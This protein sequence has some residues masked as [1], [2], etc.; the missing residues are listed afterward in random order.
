M[1][2]PRSTTPQ[3]YSTSY[4]SCL[5]QYIWYSSMPRPTYT[6]SLISISPVAALWCSV[7]PWPLI[8]PSPWHLCIYGLSPSGTLDLFCYVC[9]MLASHYPLRSKVSV[10]S[11]FTCA[12][13]ILFSCFLFSLAFLLTSLSHCYKF[14]SYVFQMFCMIHLLMG[15]YS[16][17]YYISYYTCAN[18]MPG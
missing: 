14:F 7:L 12:P 5:G 4:S 8:H 17:M 6:S 18:I 13:I 2:P 10:L 1:A 3:Y 11:V 16:H 15:F 9:M